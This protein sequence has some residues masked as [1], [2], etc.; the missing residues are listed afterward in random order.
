MPQY[1]ASAWHVFDFSGKQRAQQ[2]TKVK[3]VHQ[4]ASDKK[5][6]HEKQFTI[7]M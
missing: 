7:D 2:I 1:K 4:N 6:K 3:S 5:L